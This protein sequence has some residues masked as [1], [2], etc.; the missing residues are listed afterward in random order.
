MIDPLKNVSQLKE[1]FSLVQGAVDKKSS[2]PVSLEAIKQLAS[3]PD[4]LKYLISVNGALT[5]ALSQ[6]TL[7]TGS[8]YWADMISSQNI[9]KLENIVKKP[10]LLQNIATSSATIMSAISV[11]KLI[12]ALTSATDSS[13]TSA[14][15]TRQ[16]EGQV[17]QEMNSGDE[18][19]SEPLPQSASQTAKQTTTAPV[20]IPN[21]KTYAAETALAQNTPTLTQNT[22]TTPSQPQNTD[23]TATASQREL[24][25]S[26]PSPASKTDSA[27][28]TAHSSNMPTQPVQTLVRSAVGALIQLAKE[29]PTLTQNAAVAHDTPAENMQ[30]TSVR[31]EEKKQESQPQTKKTDDMRLMRPSGE[32]ND[33]ESSLTQKLKTFQHVDGSSGVPRQTQNTKVGTVI[34][35]NE[36]P[37]PPVSQQQTIPNEQKTD[38]TEKI[39]ILLGQNFP[40]LVENQTLFQDLANKLADLLFNT[41]PNALAEKME[42]T[43]R[44]AIAN[45][46]TPTDDAKSQKETEAANTPVQ[47]AKEVSQA[48]KAT[49]MQQSEQ[50]QSSQA[51]KMENPVA[52]FKETILQELSQTTSASDFHI[53][54][55]IAIALNKEVFTVAYQDKG[56]LQFRRKPHRYGEPSEAQSVE[57]YSAFE[58]LG[59]V[60]GEISRFGESTTLSLH[61]EFESSYQY[62]QAHMNELSFFDKKY[63]SIKH[64]IKE[65][66]EVKS[67]FLDT[68]G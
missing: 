47:Q 29:L 13:S 45:I 48:D 21:T 38:I 46:Q 22:Q 27:A 58:S 4:G 11:E 33:S 68:T 67:S 54:S 28:Q 19:A 31:P 20:L 8:Q 32:K 5:E 61:V 39:T 43:I 23:K 63:V 53:L 55:N 12:D 2:A 44:K 26:S 16:K 51:T 25:T 1:L 57:F 3:T 18:V 64:G 50:T 65:I 14:A 59:P 37:N 7:S 9:V 30:K 62:L 42:E 40:K 56:I 60:G 35:E 10:D 41:P 66:V 52:K 15:L 49:P 24:D 34:A 17:S 6:S 36:H